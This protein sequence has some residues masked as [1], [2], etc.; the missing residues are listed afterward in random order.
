M[1]NDITLNDIGLAS[2]F[3]GEDDFTCGGIAAG[4]IF[5]L[6]LQIRNKQNFDTP[7][8]AMKKNGLISRQLVGI[9]LG[10]P[11]SLSAEGAHIIFDELDET[12]YLGNIH[13][14]DRDQTSND[15]IVPMDSVTFDDKVLGCDGKPCTVLVRYGLVLVICTGC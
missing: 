14:V 12:D 1:G 3:A 5:P 10:D 6:G 7:L 9:S 15:W 13:W 11:D 2:V 8:T 4:G